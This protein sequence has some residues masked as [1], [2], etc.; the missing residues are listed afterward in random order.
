M[1]DVPDPMTGSDVRRRTRRLCATGVAIA[2]ALFVMA[3]SIAAAAAT[4]RH[5][6]D[7]QD[8]TRLSTLHPAALV[9]LEEG[10]ASAMAGD[11]TQALAAFREAGTQAADS[12]LIA[13]RECQ[14]LTLLGMRSEAITAC[15]R[16]F[17]I[18]GSAMDLR[19]MVGALMSGQEPPTATELAQAMRYAR[20]ARTMMPQEPYG[21]A[22]DCE[23]AER[24][25]DAQMLEA[26]LDDLRRVAPGHYETV[27]ALGAAAPLGLTW[28][29]GAAWFLVGLLGLGTLAH[30]LWRAV[31]SS[32]GRRARAVVAAA[33]IVA[34][35]IGS[36][37]P[38]AAQARATPPGQREHA[39]LLSDWPVDDKDPESSVPDEQRRNRNPLQFGYWLMDVTYKAVQATKRGDHPA[40][41]RYYKA[42]VKAVPDRS[43]SFTRLCEAYEAAGE[44]QNSVQAC[45]TALTRPGVT[46]ND[47]ERYVGLALKK[48]GALTAQEVQILDNVI[49]HVREDPAGGEAA[50]DLECQ[51]GVRLEDEVR[52][53]ECT[54]ALAL[55]AP[56]DPRTISYEW[57]LA[58]KL[59]NYREAA[60]IID[61]ARS[62]SMTPEGISQMVHG[63]ASIQESHKRSVYVWMLGGVAFVMLAA[64]GIVFATK[65]R[66]TLRTA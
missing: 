35:G 19:A 48:K 62:T 40:A 7:E 43:V 60:A 29:I 21:Y 26:C 24:I 3:A 52:L 23:I 8:V 16:A 58:M 65:R 28:R 51:L 36:P 38:A 54:G 18:E 46:V 17:K 4:S 5:F 63:L 50:A 66:A 44:W 37:A 30:A 6:I 2:G 61:R 20:R 49:Q 42:L 57:A 33:I 64:A 10:E 31:R 53:R 1:P 14:A 41:V 13:R 39:G 59:G 12:A 15:I 47:Y 25:H 27:R 55:K 22:A 56:D 9:F 32:S 34:W 11:T 45:A